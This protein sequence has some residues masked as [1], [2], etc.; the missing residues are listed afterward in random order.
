[1]MPLTVEIIDTGIISDAYIQ[2]AS[3][4]PV[5]QIFARADANPDLAA[6]KAA[7]RAIDAIAEGHPYCEVRDQE[8]HVL[9]VV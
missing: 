1:M 9:E 5:L 7:Q 3:G 8:L 2:A 4:I 6:A